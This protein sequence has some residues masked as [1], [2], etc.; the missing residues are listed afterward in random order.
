MKA[1]GTLANL[2]TGVN[3][4]FQTDTKG[5]YV[6][7]GL[8]Y[9]AY[10]LEVSAPGFATQSVSLD[11]QSEAPISL[12]ITMAFRTGRSGRSFKNFSLQA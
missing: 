7:T 8:A 12:T 11:V 5:T 3:R 9:G 2:S 10:R 1:P 4:R 6:F